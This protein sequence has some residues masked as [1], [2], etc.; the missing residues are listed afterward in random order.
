MTRAG[1]GRG[2]SAAATNAQ[3]TC[4]LPALGRGPEGSF[5]GTFALTFLSDWNPECQGPQILQV[6]PQMIQPGI[7][8]Y[9]VLNSKSNHLPTNTL[10]EPQ[11]L[12]SL[13]SIHHKPPYLHRNSVW[14]GQGVTSPL[15]H[16]SHQ[17]RILP[18]GSY[19]HPR[20][21]PRHTVGPLQ[22]GVGINEGPRDGRPKS[23]HLSPHPEEKP[24]RCQCPGTWAPYR[25]GWPGSGV[26]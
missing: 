12:V 9:H 15:Q 23:P 7:P 25:G 24:P 26:S 1:G 3:E 11:R 16:N 2:Q 6:S 20:Q 4:F 21:S 22:S 8:D 19:L 17:S 14:T 5:C 18:G 10:T 13:H